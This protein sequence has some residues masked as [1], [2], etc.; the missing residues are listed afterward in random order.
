MNEQ[1]SLSDRET[2]HFRGPINL[3]AT[4]I[5]RA[6]IKR[7]LHARATGAHILC[8]LFSFR[9]PSLLPFTFLFLLAFRS[10]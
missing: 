2:D 10:A 6:I 9:F 5:N 4:L 8:L 3:F 1:V 7:S